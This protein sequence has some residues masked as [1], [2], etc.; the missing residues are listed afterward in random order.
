LG[1]FGAGKPFELVQQSKAKTAILQQVKRQKNPVLKKAVD[2]IIKNDYASAIQQLSKHIKEEQNR[3]KRLELLVDNY[4]A[5]SMSLRERTLV[6]TP[7]NED[8]EVVNSLI[9]KGLKDEGT[10]YGQ[11]VKTQ[12]LIPKVLTKAEYTLAGH[13]EP[14]NVVRFNIGSKVLGIEKHSYFRVNTRD[15]VHN[16]VMLEHVETGKLIIW[17]P[18]EI[19]GGRTNA[20]EIYQADKR[21]LNVGD[22]LH[23]TRSDKTKGLTGLTLATV[24]E[25]NEDK[26]TVQLAKDQNYS[27]SVNDIKEQHID[28]AY[29]ITVFRAQGKTEMEIICHEDSQ[30]KY[31]TNQRG[32]YVSVTRAIQKVTIYTDNKEEFIKGILA[33]TGDKTSA[34]GT[35][36]EAWL[37]KRVKFPSGEGLAT[38]P[39]LSVAA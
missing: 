29:A 22:K 17:L 1:S 20:I 32:F 4:L 19:L 12:I 25:I 15:L 26:I 23:W 34:L 18:H 27:F 31:L 10:I 13:Y 9:R 3:S 33:N 14:G 11:G 30:R 7:A 5:R 38:Q 8:R 35:P 36:G 28:Y 6:I 21:E 24:K 16:A 2:T 39:G 37:S